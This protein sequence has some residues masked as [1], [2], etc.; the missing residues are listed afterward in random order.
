MLD[1]LNIQ[2]AVAAIR[3][4]LNTG[5]PVVVALM[6]STVIMWTLIIERLL[7][8]LRAQ[9]RL[10]RS[11]VAQWATRDDH[12]SW[13][14]HAIREKLISEHKLSSEQFLDLIRLFILITPLLGLLGTVT[15][16]IEVFQSITSAGSS[17]ARLLAAGIYRA[18]VPTMTGLAVS[19]SGV[20][21]MSLFDRQVARSVGSL[22]DRLD[23]HMMPS[24][25]GRQRAA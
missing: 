23:I 24:A 11:K 25:K 20:F 1:V 22:A 21:F 5:G 19:L 17:N 13:Q 12:S 16:M 4:Y 9:P 8:F 15:G 6:I 18:T 2:D 10:N 7:Y 14:A 3:G